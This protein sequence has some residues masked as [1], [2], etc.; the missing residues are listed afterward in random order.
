MKKLWILAGVCILAAPAYGARRGVPPGSYLRKPVSS[1]EELAAVISKDRV[2]QRQFATHFGVPSGQ[3]ATYIRDNVV[4]T[5]VSA[6]T[7]KS[8]YII[9]RNGQMVAQRTTLRKG[10]PIF[11]L[12]DTGEPLLV[13]KCGNPALKKLP[14][15][16]KVRA[17]PPQVY[18]LVRPNEAPLPPPVAMAP[19]SEVPPLPPPTLVAASPAPAPVAA[20]PP[21]VVAKKRV[22]LPLLGG[23]FAFH[24]GEKPPPPIPEPGGAAAVTATALLPA[25]GWAIRRIRCRGRTNESANES[26]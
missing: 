3:L 12:K 4:I 5:R 21:T 8:V 13:L 22:L 20:A 1:V 26:A 10:T 2:V 25:A 24:R 18:Q 6:N 15:R 9:R 14:P 7:P 19:P 16:E 23:L 17:G 11:A